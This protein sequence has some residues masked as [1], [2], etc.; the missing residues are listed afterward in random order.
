MHISAY[1]V[2]TIS[3]CKVDNDKENY[4]EHWNEQ[5]DPSG[6]YTYQSQA[7]NYKQDV[8]H[9]RVDGPRNWRGVRTDD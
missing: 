9:V 6:F 1:F 8:V 4:E 7:E 2:V 3:Q 5:I